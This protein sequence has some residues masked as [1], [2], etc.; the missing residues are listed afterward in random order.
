MEERTLGW[1]MREKE[2]HGGKNDER[3]HLTGATHWGW[4]PAGGLMVTSADL[5]LAVRGVSIGQSGLSFCQE[6]RLRGEGGEVRGE[7]RRR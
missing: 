2:V 1:G 6:V 4:S 5:A 3:S 7:P